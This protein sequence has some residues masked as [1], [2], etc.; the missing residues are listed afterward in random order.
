MSLTQ[1]Q[2]FA[3]L[4]AIYRT[5]DAQLGGPLQALFAVLTGQSSIVEAN[6]QQLYDDQFIETCASWAIP[7]IGDLIGYNSLYQIDLAGLDS[8]AEVANTIS[9]RRHKG[10]L[11]A[12]EQLSADV[13]GRPAI[14]V[15][16]FKNLITTESM[17]LVR[18]THIS[19][20]DLRDNAAL[21]QL[22]QVDSPFDTLSRTIDVRRIGPRVRAVQ[23]PDP[24]PLDIALHGGGTSNVLDVGI[25]LWRW[26]SFP[27]SNAP[28]FVVGNGRYRFS[29][30]GNDIPLF[31]QTPVRASFSGLTTRIDV[32]Q[33]IDRQEFQD[34]LKP[35]AS[36]TFYGMSILLIADNLN[37]PATRIV[38]ANLSDRAG[39]AWCEPPKGMIAID[40]VLG[41]IQYAAD[42]T[43]PKSLRV[44]YSYGFPAEIGGG[45]YDRSAS[46]NVP[47]PAQTKLY[48]VIGTTEHPTVQSAVTAW[49]GLPPGTTGVIVLPNY[50]SYTIDFTGKNALQLP[51]GSSLTVLSGQPL[52]PPPSGS[53]PDPPDVV[54]N[55]SCATLVGNIQ[56]EATATKPLANGEQ[57]PAGQ[58]LFSGLKIAGQLIIGGQNAAVQ[59]IDSTLVP[60]FG[61]TSDGKALAAGEPS[62]VVTATEAALSLLNSI[63]GPIAA[64]TGGSTRICSSIVDATSPYYAAYTASDLASAGADLQVQGSTIIGKVHAR[65]ITLA[66]N[67]IFYSRLGQRDPWPAAVWSSR[68]QT[69]CVR[70]CWLPFNSI[71]PQRYRC[72]PPDAASEAALTPD[73]VSTTCGDPSYALLSGYVPMAVWQGSDSGSQIGVY[74]GI[75]ETEAVRNV[76]LRAPE[77]LP[78]CL[79]SGIFLHPSAPPA[80]I[81]PAP[82]YYQSRATSA[83]RDASAG[84]G[85][86]L[87]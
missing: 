55:N 42:L 26:K 1:D 83:E 35:G 16:E 69:G 21:E 36:P 72:L 63:S 68:R 15:E 59:L 19:T 48:A 5:R 37:V 73:F 30:L 82:S 33:P 3:L 10:T 81:I 13:S 43:L 50:E 11:I 79:E 75:Q 47:A 56:V 27:V 20:V 74:G 4:P 8:R 31:N 18:P 41:R 34:S 12:L 49:N 66:S 84:I 28:A 67:T 53:A 9:Y 24:T 71:T 85:S 54:W 25:H 70:F 2:F 40:P 14:A 32:P 52:A 6:I 78:V 76:Q 23:S 60:G 57:P 51:A 38:C 61:F 46:L 62:I 80:A 39:G 77:Y 45:Q 17:R 7:Y 58:L 65:T 44:N 86:S 29:S 22:V 87:V 64:D